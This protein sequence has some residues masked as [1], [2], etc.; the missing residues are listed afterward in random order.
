MPTQQDKYVLEII[1]QLFESQ[2]HVW[3]LNG[4]F[5]GD[6][7]RD[8]SLNYETQRSGGGLP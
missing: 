6:T 4:H 7:K 8:H 2:R 3:D 5:F 1:Q